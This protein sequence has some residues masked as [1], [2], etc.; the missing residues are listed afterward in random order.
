MSWSPLN[1][2]TGRMV[3]V[4]ITAVALSHLV[5]FWFYAQER[6]AAV[7]RAVESAAVERIIYTVERLDR[8]PIERRAQVAQS[9]RDFGARF[10]L[11]ASPDVTQAASSGPAARIAGAVAQETGAETAAAARTVSRSPRWR[12]PPR[13]HM[14]EHVL[15]HGE[16]PPHRATHVTEVTVSVRLDESQWLNAR[17]HIPRPRPLPWGVLAGALV[18]I[19]AVGAGA[20]LVSRQI[21]RPL[22]DLANAAQSF[23]AGAE[24]VST[25]ETG[26]ADVRRASRAFNDMAARLGRQFRRQRQMLWAL[27]HDLRTPI[28][29]LKLR[30]ELVED[31]S[32]RQRILAPIADMERLTEQALALARAGVSEEPRKRVDI[33]DIARTLCAELAE[34]GLNLRAEA[35]TPAYATCRPNDIARLLRNLAENAAK[36]GGGGVMRVRAE[37]TDVVIEVLDEGPGVPDELLARLAEPFFRADPARSETSDGVGLGLAIAQ[38]VAD[39]HGAR[40]SFANRKA[41]GFA[42]T[43][44]LSAGCARQSLQPKQASA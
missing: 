34:L 41:R 10:S 15:H 4:T 17:I 2:L 16:P 3:L 25:P 31:E 26:P 27:S 23:G 43:L 19:F 38:A 13:E 6:G 33:A 7:S 30:A 24:N 28:T 35:E 18:S 42:A 22:S 37:N 8:V 44:V 5:V 14:R 39:S 36:H 32:A 20:A 40:L 21:G 11:S 1:S 9:I 12:R 29:A